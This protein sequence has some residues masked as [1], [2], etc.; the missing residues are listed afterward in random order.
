VTATPATQAPAPQTNPA[1]VPDPPAVA[2]VQAPQKPNVPAQKP[3]DPPKPAPAPE[4]VHEPPPAPVAKAQPKPPPEPAAAEPK[5]T[6]E[7][8]PAAV[9]VASPDVVRPVIPEVPAKSRSTIHGKVPITV[10]VEVDADGT[11][12]ESKVESGASSKYFAEIALQAARQWKFVPG[13][14]S[15][16]WNVRFEFTQSAQHPV[17]AQATPT[18]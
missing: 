12:I 15:R 11:V 2:A 17:S 16:A 9:A 4:S 3:A 5:Q 14:G 18:H 7:V 13:E 6:Q 10:R 1:P 8:A